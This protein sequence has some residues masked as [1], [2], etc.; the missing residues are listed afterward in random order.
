MVLHRD[1]PRTRNGSHLCTSTCPWALHLGSTLGKPKYGVN[2]DSDCSFSDQDEEDSAGGLRARVQSRFL[3]G[4]SVSSSSSGS[5]SS[6]S[7]GSLSSS[8]ICSTDNEDFSE[9][10]DE[11]DSAMLLQPC[12]THPVPALLAQHAE[13]GGQGS[14]GCFVSGQ[15]AKQRRKGTPSNFPKTKEPLP[16][17]QRLPSVENRPKIS[18]FLPA[19]QLWRWSGEPT[20]RGGDERKSKKTLLQVNCA[21][22]GDLACGRMCSFPVGRTPKPALHWTH[23]EHVGIL[24]RQYGGESQV[25]LPS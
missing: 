14:R 13:D 8:S 2:C 21:G 16:R 18:T 12:L 24:G 1:W 4:L 19:R 9:S 22:E 10:S 25:V 3:A 5:S 17:Q 6:S 15:K 7:S 23:R 20:Q 11:A